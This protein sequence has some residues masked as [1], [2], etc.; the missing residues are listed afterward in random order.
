MY[1]TVSVQSLCVACNFFR[2]IIIVSVFSYIW[3]E[4]I[5]TRIDNI[6]ILIKVFGEHEYMKTSNNTESVGNGKVF[7]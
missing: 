1:S 6:D 3:T 5:K 2:G 7:H 4:N